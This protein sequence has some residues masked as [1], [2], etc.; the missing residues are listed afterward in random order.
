MKLRASDV[1]LTTSTSSV[2]LRLNVA[3][4]DLHTSVT[5]VVPAAHIDYIFLA[6][7]AYMDTSGLFQFKGETL[8]TLDSSVISIGKFSSEALAITDLA[9]LASTKPIVE[10]LTAVDIAANSVDLVKPEALTASDTS[11]LSF[12]FGTVQE[13]LVTFDT[14]VLNPQ[15][16]LTDS[17]A[18][19]DSVVVMLIF[20]R[21]FSEA[22]TLT[23][24][25]VLLV[26]PAYSDSIG[27]SESSTLGY[28]QYLSDAFAMND[29]ADI[30]DGIAFQF[31]DYTN[32]VVSTSDGQVLL[33]SPA[34][35]DT[36]SLSD[37]GVGSMQN[38]SDITYFAED[39][40]GSRFT[41]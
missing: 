7:S 26:L 2:R 31:D 35:S 25:P 21:S 38:Y 41:F 6:T 8:T 4:V 27:V 9:A 28:N 37:T 1:S 22:T 13:S 30:G 5:R 20:L 32:N 34:Y 12:A 11:A 18:L 23:D 24:T 17:A 15:L 19:S 29:M 36:I 16:G 39:Y 10:A 40:V 3:V 14:T 33:V